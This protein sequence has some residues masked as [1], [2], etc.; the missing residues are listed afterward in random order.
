MSRKASPGP[1]LSAQQAPA[2]LRRY[3]TD[4]GPLDQIQDEDSD[5][6]DLLPP[7]MAGGVAGE[8]GLPGTGACT[9]C[10]SSCCVA[11]QPVPASPCLACRAVYHLEL[12][13]ARWTAAPLLCLLW[14]AA[15]P[16]RACSAPRTLRR[17]RAARAHHPHTARFAVPHRPQ[18]GSSHYRGP[19][20]VQVREGGGRALTH[21]DVPVVGVCLRLTKCTDGGCM[22]GVAAACPAPA[23]HPCPCPQLCALQRG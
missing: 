11:C 12:G 1:Q 10:A 18:L 4:A 7:T 2:R 14:R 15:L 13:L 9:S 16:T 19:A 20:A 5:A 21:Y 17:R 8:S 6:D 3:M 22:R 23:T